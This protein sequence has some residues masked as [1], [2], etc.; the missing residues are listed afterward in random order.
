MQS[1]MQ[2][3]VNFA[4]FLKKMF[5]SEAS[6]CLSSLFQVPG[7]FA[8]LFTPYHCLPILFTLFGK[9]FITRTLRLLVMSTLFFRAKYQLLFAEFVR[10]WVHWVVR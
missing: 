10:F 8:V 3:E 4:F 2:R 7:S 5:L 9:L 1:G 6:L